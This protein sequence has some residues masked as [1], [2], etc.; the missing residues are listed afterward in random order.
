MWRGGKAYR[1]IRNQL[2]SVRLVVD[3]K[4]TPATV[5]QR[6]DHDEYGVTNKERAARPGSHPR[7]HRQITFF[8]AVA[9]V[10][11]C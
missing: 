5:M 1:I 3:T 2:G 4:T 10:P 9:D 7:V 11:H 6:I 8:L